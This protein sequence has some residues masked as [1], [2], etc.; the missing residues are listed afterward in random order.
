MN[1]E[2]ERDVA[3]EYQIMSI[4][5]LM[6][7]KQ[8]ILV[9]RQAGALPEKALEELVTKVKDLDMDKVRAEMAKDQ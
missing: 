1:T 8:K 7:F 2:N 6:I 9:F 5:T 4:P 3:G